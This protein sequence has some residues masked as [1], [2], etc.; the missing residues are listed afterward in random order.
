M[1]GAQHKGCPLMLETGPEPDDR[2]AITRVSFSLD[3]PYRFPSLLS[4]FDR[5]F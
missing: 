4:H 1:L 5:H 3:D 2:N